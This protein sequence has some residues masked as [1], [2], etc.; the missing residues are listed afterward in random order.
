MKY[1]N[2]IAVII[3]YYGSFPWYF[4]YFLHSCK[5]NESI[6]FFIFSDITHKFQVPPNVKIIHKSIEE[7]KELAS[8]KLGFQV[9]LDFPYKLC[10]FKPAYGLIFE[11]YI[12]LYDY[13]AQSD[14]DIIYGNLRNFITDDFLNK[15]DFISVRHDYT[16]GCFALYKNNML[17]K[18]IFKRSKDYKIVF[19]NSKHYCFD[20]CNFAW[21]YLTEGKTIFEIETEIES[22][23]HVIKKTEKKNEINAHFDFILIEGLVGKIIF[24]RGTIV[25]KK[26]FEGILYHLYWLKRVYNPKKNPRIIPDKYFISPRKIYH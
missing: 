7:I 25:Y 14:I 24:D 26:M 13:W 11:D 1:K 2:K 15:Y 16:S 9:N 6:D 10:D 12:K 18:N 3:C 23:T 17:M 5:F 8:K 21:D 4:P 22:F 19:S 20:E